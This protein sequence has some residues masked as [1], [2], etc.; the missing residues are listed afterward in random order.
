MQ[1]DLIAL[2]SGVGAYVFLAILMAA[3][4]RGKPTTNPGTSFLTFRHHILLRGFSLFLAFGMPIGITALIIA[5]PPK[6]QG[7]YLAILIIYAL[8]AALGVPLL[9]ESMRFALVIGPKGLDCHSPWRSRQFILWDEVEEVSYNPLLAW[10]VIRAVGG[11][12][13]RVPALVSGL[14]AFLEACEQRLP[15]AKL[16]RAKAGYTQLG[17]TFPGD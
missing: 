3:A 16:R 10:H 8:F 14:N 1:H 5:M 12:K 2:V 9:W 11:E 7:D 15:P 4:K 17:R 13:F 6:D